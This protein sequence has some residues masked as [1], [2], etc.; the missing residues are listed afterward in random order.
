MSTPDRA[1]RLAEIKQELAELRAR[2]RAEEAPLIEER[3]AVVR[4][5]RVAGWS[6]R[7]IA[8]EAGLA[9]RTVQEI[10]EANARDEPGT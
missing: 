1:A 2:H 10:L 6:L 3:T 5:L 7:R 4:E 8:R 9:L